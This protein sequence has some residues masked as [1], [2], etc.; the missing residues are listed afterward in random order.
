MPEPTER[1]NRGSTPASLRQPRHSEVQP[2]TGR[3]ISDDVSI[4]ARSHAIHIPPTGKALYEIEHEALELTLQLT[5]FNKSAAARILGISRPTLL[6][7]LREHRL[8][9]GNAASRL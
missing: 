6:R 3:R 9:R 7:K 4:A 1:T 2:T 5:R 8:R